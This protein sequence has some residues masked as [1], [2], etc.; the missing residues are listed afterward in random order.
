MSDITYE[1]IVNFLFQ[2]EYY[3]TIYNICSQYCLSFRPT[4]IQK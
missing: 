3:K 2:E 1:F 4:T